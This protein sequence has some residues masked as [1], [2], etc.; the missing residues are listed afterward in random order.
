MVFLR[1]LSVRC[2]V[3]VMILLIRCVCARAQA[4]E[5]SILPQTRI[6]QAAARILQSLDNATCR[7]QEC[8]IVVTNFTFSS[9]LTSQLG[10]DL[11]DQFAHELASQASPIQV[12]GRSQI[13]SDLERQRI[14]GSFFTDDKAIRWLGQAVGAT[15][16]LTGG[17]EKSGPSMLLKVRLLACW[18]E[19]AGPEESITFSYSGLESDLSPTE[20]FPEEPPTDNI[21]SDPAL[22]RVGKSGV[23]RPACIYCPNPGFTQAARDAKASGTILLD[24]VISP[25][26]SATDARIIRGAPFGL[27][28]RAMSTVRN[29]KFK[30][31]TL[32][33]KPV[34]AIVQVEVLFRFY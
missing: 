23:T 34:T 7:S 18:T 24:V 9:G 19:K 13:R 5:S 11:A 22:P 17:L 21:F 30:P 1:N 31:S 8:R 4:S 25:Q 12:M 32:N 33:G 16:I 3:L 15:A 6:R 26:G 28:E 27:N 20:A 2:A 14:P 29:W 10:M